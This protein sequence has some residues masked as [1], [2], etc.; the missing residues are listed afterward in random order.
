VNAQE[1]ERLRIARE[2]HDDICQRITAVKIHM[3]ALEAH[4]P[5]LPSLIL[6]KIRMVKKQLGNSINEIRRVSANLRPLALDDLGLVAALRLVCREFEDLNSIKVVF[7]TRN[8]PAIPGD[9]EVEITLY[10]VV[11]E[12]LSN[13]LKHARASEVEVTLSYHAH[14][15]SL[16]IRDN[17][18]GFD[19]AKLSARK[20]HSGFGLL[21]IRERVRLIG[22][23]VEIT[24]EKKKGTTVRISVPDGMVD[25]EKNKNHTRR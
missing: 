13:I 11:Q 19:V 4:R 22:G 17:G 25:D 7:T 12:A 24:S 20:E 2:L 10:R 21:N 1:E 8:L 5:N 15:R 18:K 23:T 3:D 16:V 6:N 14:T 9:E